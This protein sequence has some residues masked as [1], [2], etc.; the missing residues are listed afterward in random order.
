MTQEFNGLHPLKSISFW[1]IHTYWVDEDECMYTQPVIV[2]G[3]SQV[4]M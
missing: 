3:S 4:I 1:A 2:S